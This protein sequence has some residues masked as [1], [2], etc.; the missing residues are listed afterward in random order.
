MSSSINKELGSRIRIFR[1]QRGLAL[2]EFATIARIPW[3]VLADIENGDHF[4]SMCQIE[5]LL[6][7]LNTTWSE[8]TAE[9]LD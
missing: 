4:P 7:A 8:L 1:E 9:F 2:E 3:A 5:R 6:V